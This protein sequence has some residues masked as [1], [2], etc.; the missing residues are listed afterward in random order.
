MH[1]KIHGE[2][3]NNDPKNTCGKFHDNSKF[4]RKNL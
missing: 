4:Y 1:F 3:K 2:L